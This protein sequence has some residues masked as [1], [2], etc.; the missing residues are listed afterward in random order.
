VQLPP[1]GWEL[2]TTKRDKRD[3]C[4][5][6]EMGEKRKVLRFARAKTL[7]VTGWISQVFLIWTVEEKNLTKRW[8]YRGPTHSGTKGS[9]K[10][11]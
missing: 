4:E 9:K 8:N 11:R 5:V 2:T 6:G 10:L 1:H 7:K 3:V